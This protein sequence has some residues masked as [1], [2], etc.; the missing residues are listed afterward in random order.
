MNFFTQVQWSPYLVGALI[1]ALNLLSMLLSKKP[2]GASTSY[3]KVSGILRKL[4]NK[5]MVANNEYYKKK[6]PE[7][8]WGIM[9]VLGII[10]GS[11]FS[12]LIS[13]DFN[14]ILVPNM[15]SQRFSDAFLPRF[16][17]SILGGILLGFGSR[18]AGGCTSGHGISGSSQLSPLSWIAAI[19]FFIGGIVTALLIYGI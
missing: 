11:F 3:L 2:L 16:F 10:I 7:L 12:A 8:D 6:N 14:L 1:G 5:E 17:A 15:W 13:N 9:L 19:S 4:Y 18:W